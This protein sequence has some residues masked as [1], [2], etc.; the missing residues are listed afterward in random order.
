[1]AAFVAWLATSSVGYAQSLPAGPLS[2][3]GGALTV[4]GDV[5]ATAG[6]DDPG[7][8]TYTSYDRS[9]LRLM[10]IDLTASARAG[11]HVTLLGQ[12]RTQNFGRVDVVAAYVRVRPWAHR[13]IDVQAGRI[14]PT[15][16][17]FARR[18][19]GQD[20]PLVGLP[21]AYQY[22]TSLRTDSLPLDGEELLRMRGRGWLSRFTLGNTEPYH[23]L[24]LVNALQWDT[25]LQVHAE[26]DVVEVTGAVTAG[27]ISN[28]RLRDATGLRQLVARAVVRPM[29]GLVLGT[30]VARGPFLTSGAEA[31]SRS[32]HDDGE[33]IQTSLGADAEYS[34]GHTL[35]R[36]ELMRTAWNVPHLWSATAGRPLT[37][38]ALSMEV[39]QTLRPGLYAAGRLEHLGFSRI[40]GQ[41][42]QSEWEA[43][44]SRIEVGGGYRLTRSLELKAS[45]QHNRRETF[46]FGRFTGLASQLA[47]WF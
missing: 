30:S 38:L 47:Y 26:S 28:P 35:V 43:P 29:T 22:L 3:A 40:T 16:G 1:M 8:F 23:G 44:V 15:F 5:L 41:G 4:G 20:N 12:L 19:Y 34:R 32:R 2:L 24:P 10:Q 14:P 31:W 9:L 45:F 25:G 11:R 27:T 46:R 13:R 39:R 18:A 36:G 33:Y 7:F 21:L 17:G 42:R 6:P 37:A